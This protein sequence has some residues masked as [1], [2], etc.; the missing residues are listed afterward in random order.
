M[1]N[2]TF[3]R[4]SVS[5]PVAKTVLM[6]EPVHFGYNPET[7]VN[8]YFQKASGNQP[9]DLQHRALQ[10]YLAMVEKLRAH[11]IEVISVK[12]TAFPHTPDSIFPNNWISFHEDG[13]IVFYPMFAP[14]RRLERRP[15]IAGILELHGHKC[16]N[17]DDFS[18][19]EEENRFLEGTGSMILDRGNK[20]AYAAISE[21]TD[22]SLFLQFCST[23]GYTPV[24]F[25]ANQSVGNERKAIY[26]T[27][28][29]LCVADQ[30]A[31]ICAESIDDGD[32][33]K[34]V[35]DCLVNSGKSLIE[36]TENQM[37]HFAGN[38]LQLQ[39]G[40][41]VR[42]LVMSQSAFDVLTESQRERLCA[43][44]ACIVCA[45]PSIESAGGGSVRC[46]M[47]EVFK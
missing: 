39:N 13:Q 43:F 33:R 35:L 30:Y 12:D 38:M 18:F 4:Q 32:E 31:V 5:Y 34:M 41:G 46:M 29:M 2:N 17:I 3:N 23:F 9:D 19:W 25:T 28:V 24:S 16:S 44:N 1:I 36:I 14:N 40:E 22:K 26:H 10:E 20:I 42:F 37:Y 21:R 15:D 45:I 27:N 11:G 47:A 6:I 8:N 7:A